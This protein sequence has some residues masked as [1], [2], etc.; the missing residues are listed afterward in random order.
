VALLLAHYLIRTVMH[1]AAPKPTSHRIGEFRSYVAYPS[2]Q[3]FSSA[4][5][6]ASNKPQAVSTAVMRMDR[7]NCPNARTY[8]PTRNQTQNVKKFGLKRAQHYHWPQPANLFQRT[9]IV[10][11]YPNSIEAKP[12]SFVRPENRWLIELFMRISAP[13]A[14]S[15]VRI[16]SE[17]A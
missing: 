14:A 16:F 2:V 5:I 17:R 15:T 9:P 10:P 11:T 4:Q 1:E 13:I 3:L 6:V 8:Q 7:H 12:S